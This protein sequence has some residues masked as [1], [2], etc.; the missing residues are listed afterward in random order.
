MDGQRLGAVEHQPMMTAVDG[1]RAALTFQRQGIAFAGHGHVPAL[2][3]EGPTDVHA[4]DIDRLG[5]HRAGF[6]GLDQQRRDDQ[7]ATQQCL[8]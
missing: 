7:T 5:R 3:V 4:V 8:E 1:H 6:L 2:A